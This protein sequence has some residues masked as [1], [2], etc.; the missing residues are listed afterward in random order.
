ML[1]VLEDAKDQSQESVADP[2]YQEE[3]SAADALKLLPAILEPLVVCN[4]WYGG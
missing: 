2:S 4:S 3:E 1:V